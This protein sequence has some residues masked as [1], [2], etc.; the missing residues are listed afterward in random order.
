MIL[1][2][3]KFFSVAL[4]NALKKLILPEYCF[5]IITLI[6]GT[7]FALLIPAGAGADEPNHIARVQS[8]AQGNLFADQVTDRLGYTSPQDTEQKDAVLYGAMVD[9]ALTDIAW[10]NMYKF[11][12]GKGEDGQALYAFPTWETEGV[13]ADRHLGEGTHM[14]AFSNTA[15]NT[16]IVYVPYIVGYWISNLFTN[17]AYAI[18]LVMRM[19]G[20]LTSAAIIF[21][22]IRVIPVGK[23]IVTTVALIPSMIVFNASITADTVTFAVCI[24]FLTQLLRVCVAKGRPSR[25]QWV[26][27][28]VSTLLLAM[29]KMS[30]L[31]FA[32]MLLLIPLFNISMR[33]LKMVLA[34]GALGVVTGIVFLLWYFTISGINTGAMFNVGASPSLQKKVILSDPVGFMKILF[35]Q[36]FAQNYF[37]LNYFGVPDLHGHLPYT[38]WITILAL[39]CSTSMTDSRECG[40]SCLKKHTPLFTLACYFVCACVFVLIC[41]ALYLQFNT[42]AATEI[43]GIQPRYFLPIL[44]LLLMPIFVSYH[45]STESNELETS[46]YFPSVLMLMAQSASA[47]GTFYV[48]YTTLYSLYGLTN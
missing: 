9:N 23:W 18:I 48:L 31:P 13:G 17:N 40:F 19:F 12:A 2:F 22:C 41:T 3:W 47:F 26:L 29:V 14:E 37:N 44:P 11:H 25:M 28:I 30:Y 7:C 10:S 45:K 36:F 20:L 43:D 4:V 5:L 27:L 42:V 16:P 33:T 35:K 24:L 1:R 21:Y 6:V 15:V 39:C 32:A 34:V 8:L 38:G 46:K